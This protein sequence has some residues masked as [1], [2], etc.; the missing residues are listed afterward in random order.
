MPKVTMVSYGEVV[1]K[2]RIWPA[3]TRKKLADLIKTWDPVE[4]PQMPKKRQGLKEG[5][6][7]KGGQ[8]APP[9]SPRPAPPQGQGV[10]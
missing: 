8:N 7:K 1:G 2:V 5:R 4:E 10:A 9:T 3:A 6:S